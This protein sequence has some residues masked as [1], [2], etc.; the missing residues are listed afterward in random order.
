MNNE[1]TTQRI[2]ERFNKEIEE[3]KRKRIDSGIDKKKKST[4]F[5]SDLI[6]RHKCW[7]EIK[8]DI[9]IFVSEGKNE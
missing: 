8:K 7:K 2:G 1:K 4:R 9:I 6:I 5:L 3:I